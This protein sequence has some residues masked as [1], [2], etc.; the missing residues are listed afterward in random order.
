MTLI[1]CML[2]EITKDYHVLIVNVRKIV[3][4]NL[5]LSIQKKKKK[6]TKKTQQRHELGSFTV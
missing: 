2:E 4:V 1:T 3:V 6:E 5:M